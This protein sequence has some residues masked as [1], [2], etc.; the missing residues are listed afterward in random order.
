M[1]QMIS[2]FG[3]LD[4][5][6]IESVASAYSALEHYGEN[7]LALAGHVEDLVTPGIGNRRLVS[8][9]AKDAPRVIE[10]NS[11]VLDL[12]QKAIAQLNVFLGSI[13]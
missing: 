7:L 5:K 9:P 10:M 13:R 12:T 3:L 11:G 6:T 8:V 2:K 1:P 4:Q